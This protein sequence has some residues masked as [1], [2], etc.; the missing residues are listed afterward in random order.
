MHQ[1]WSPNNFVYRE[2]AYDKL[3][4][5]SFTSL[6]MD[7]RQDM[8]IE[9]VLNSA[10]ALME[11]F[12]EGS[13]QGFGKLSRK[14]RFVFVTLLIWVNGAIPSREYFIKESAI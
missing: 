5:Q 2:A 6:K 14:S 7:L 9:E 12:L 10:G 11:H 1:F 3:R 4:A 8:N 13:A